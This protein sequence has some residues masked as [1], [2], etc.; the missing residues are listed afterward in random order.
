MG[1]VENKKRCGPAIKHVATHL[2]TLRGAAPEKDELFDARKSLYKYTAMFLWSASYGIVENKRGVVEAGGVEL[3]A[4]LLR[5]PLADF[6]T[7]HSAA[8][9]LWHLCELPETCNALTADAAAVRALVRA[10]TE[11]GVAPNQIVV[12]CL[13]LSSLANFAEKSADVVRNAGGF[14]ALQRFTRSNDATKYESSFVWTTVKPLMDLLTSKCVQDLSVSLKAQQIF[15]DRIVFRFP[16]VVELGCFL[17]YTVCG[18]GDIPKLFSEGVVGCLKD[19]ARKGGESDEYAQSARLAKLTLSN[20]EISIEDEEALRASTDG[21]L[22]SANSAVLAADLPQWLKTLGL[23]EYLAVLEDNKVRFSDLVLLTE[24]DI[25]KLPLPLGPRRR[26][27]N[28]VRSLRAAQAP[29]TTP[30]PALASAASSGGPCLVCFDSPK[31]TVLVPCGHVATCEQCSQILRAR[32]DRCVV[33]RTP[34]ERIVKPF[35]V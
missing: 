4:S 27:Q 6:S 7:I 16:Q 24:E 14:E 26:L 32:R 15:T 30:P 34:I 13:A 12:G 3:L 23:S 19:L 35:F 31:D 5:H 1:H 8:G 10:A 18:K 20:L 28:A 11:A 22:S 2:E 17:S 21:A 29:Q 25:E 33:C 9:A